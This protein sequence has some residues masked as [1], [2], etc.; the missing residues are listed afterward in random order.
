[1]EENGQNED[2]HRARLGLGN[3]SETKQWDGIARRKR[4]SFGG[5]LRM[6]RRTMGFEIRRH[7]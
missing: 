3:G 4:V 2:V 5:T 7:G 1:M 6:A